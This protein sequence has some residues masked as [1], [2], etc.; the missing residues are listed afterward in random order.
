[1]VEVCGILPV[2]AVPVVVFT[3]VAVTELNVF[4]FG[5]ASGAEADN[6]P[7][8]NLKISDTFVSDVKLL[9]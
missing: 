7:A 8:T 5:D 6:N 3:A 4:V 2:N 9:K 1:M